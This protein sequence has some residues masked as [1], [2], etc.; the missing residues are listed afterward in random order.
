MRLSGDEDGDSAAAA[1]EPAAKY[2]A[3]VKIEAAVL[4]HLCEVAP[5]AAQSGRGEDG[6]VSDGVG[7]RAAM[8]DLGGFTS[9]LPLRS[10]E[11]PF[12]A[13]GQHLQLAQWH[14]SGL[15][16]GM[17]SASQMA[18][19][20]TPPVVPGGMGLSMSKLSL[21]HASPPH[22][23]LASRKGKGIA[24]TG[25]N[26]CR[27]ATSSSQLSVGGADV[28]DSDGANQGLADLGATRSEDLD[29]MYDPMLN[30]YYDPKTNKYYELA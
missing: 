14:P 16:S 20:Y 4:S 23:L 21:S 27:G 24:M 22:A 15:H 1:M 18:R 30:C 9:A 13:S 17:A 7:G 2:P 25:A 5:A 8:Q 3:A 19:L 26:T 29:L 12:L 6:P 28:P 10:A 11:P